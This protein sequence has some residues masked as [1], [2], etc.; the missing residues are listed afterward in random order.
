M[1]IN[2]IILNFFHFAKEQNK[3]PKQLLLDGKYFGDFYNPW[4]NIY[5][6]IF[7]ILREKSLGLSLCF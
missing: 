2:N 3:L 6:K 4:I 1:Q 7:C 5:R